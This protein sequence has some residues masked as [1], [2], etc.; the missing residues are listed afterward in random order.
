MFM[1]TLLLHNR[2]ALFTQ[3]SLYNTN[4]YPIATKNTISEKKDVIDK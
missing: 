2:L 3:S 4:T 1:K